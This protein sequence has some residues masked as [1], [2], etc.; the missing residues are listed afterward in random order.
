M[1]RINNFGNW[2][3][4]L[5]MMLVILFGTMFAVGLFIAVLRWIFGGGG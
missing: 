1:K 5:T 2:A 4:A 3:V